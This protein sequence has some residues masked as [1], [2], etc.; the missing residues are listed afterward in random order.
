MAKPQL[1]LCTTST[2]SYTADFGDLYQK[3]VVH[4]VTPGST[5]EWNL[6]VGIGGSW[7]TGLVAA[8]SSTTA[9]T[10][11]TTST[12]PFSAV[13]L[14]VIATTSTSKTQIFLGVL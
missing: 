13:R 5:F 7:T 11:T 14:N 6:D 10:V 12:G 9:V 1:F 3:A 8:T 2:G 4:I